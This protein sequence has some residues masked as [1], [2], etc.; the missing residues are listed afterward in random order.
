MIMVN[1]FITKMITI[2]QH[3]TGNDYKELHIC[4]S[5]HLI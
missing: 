4:C 1:A 2:S 5:L 3:H